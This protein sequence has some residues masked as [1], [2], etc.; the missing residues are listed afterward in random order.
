MSDDQKLQ[1]VIVFLTT[2]I[3]YE[4]ECV[5]VVDSSLSA[6]IRH[7]ILMLLLHYFVIGALFARKKVN[8]ILCCNSKK[9]LKNF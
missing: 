7:V 9:L 1:F 4:C 8:C 6:F 2:N 5:D 3:V